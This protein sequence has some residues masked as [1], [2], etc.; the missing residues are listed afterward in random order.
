[1]ILF[2]RRLFFHYG[3]YRNYPLPPLAAFK[4]A[5]RIVRI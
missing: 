3:V 2:L 1:M 4:N 5:W